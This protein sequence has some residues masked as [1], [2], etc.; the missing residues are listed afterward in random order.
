MDAR[1]F[2]VHGN[3]HASTDITCSGINIT[4]KDVL[5]SSKVKVLLTS[6]QRSLFNT[7]S[8]HWSRAVVRAL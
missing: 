1:K 6:L 4:K 5:T 7:V 2:D 3:M 8:L